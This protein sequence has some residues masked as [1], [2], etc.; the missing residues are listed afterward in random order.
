LNYEH[1]AFAFYEESEKFIR[2][3]FDKVSEMDKA[4]IF[5]DEMDCLLSSRDQQSST[6]GDGIINEFLV[7]MNG[8]KSLE[9]FYGTH[10]ILWNS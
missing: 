5:I 8:S 9:Q 10:K 3:I 7:E 1:R 4:I 6:I 2:G